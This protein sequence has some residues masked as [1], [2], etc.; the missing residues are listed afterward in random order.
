MLIGASWPQVWEGVDRNC[1]ATCDAGV[2]LI[3]IDRP[4]YGR[5]A[6]QAGRSYSSNGQ[7]FDDLLAELGIPL[8]QPVALL[9]YSSGGPNALAA[10]R[11]AERRSQ[12]A[13]VGLVASNAPV[14]P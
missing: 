6:F 10:A 11:F 1:T 4:G 12:I 5:S 13:A 3:A 14:S 7:E 8:D 9:G 2:R